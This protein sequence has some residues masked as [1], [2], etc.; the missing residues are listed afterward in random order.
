MRLSRFAQKTAKMAPPTRQMPSMPSA[1]P[2][3]HDEVQPIVA[4]SVLDGMIGK[5]SEK[6]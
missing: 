3:I 6:N 4:G 2:D 1:M 5:F